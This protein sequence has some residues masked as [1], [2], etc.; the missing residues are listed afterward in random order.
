MFRARLAWIAAGLATLAFL[1]LLAWR[2]EAPAPASQPSLGG[3]F[4]LEN[5]SGRPVDQR[6]FDGKWTALY[7][8]YTYCP[9]V[10]PTTLQTLAQAEHGLGDKLAAFQVVFVTVDPERDTPS[11]LKAYLASDAFPPGIIGLTGTPAQIAPMARA[12]GVYYQKQGAGADYSVNHSS[13]IYL[14]DPKGRFDSVIPYGLTP[15]ETRS[16]ILKAMNAK[17]A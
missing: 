11:Q 12:Y 1:G 17:G 4:N 8:G 5:Q 6:V 15:E 10:C 13:A 7:F 16:D 9:D 3:P 2:L 14:I